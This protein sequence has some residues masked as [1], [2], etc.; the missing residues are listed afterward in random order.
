MAP[1]YILCICI[2]HTAINNS[3][4]EK[5]MPFQFFIRLT[6]HHVCMRRFTCLTKEK[7]F[8]AT[9]IINS[10]ALATQNFNANSKKRG[11]LLSSI[12]IPWQSYWYWY[13]L[14]DCVHLLLVFTK[15][16]YLHAYRRMAYTFITYQ[17]V[18]LRMR[19]SIDF[20]WNP[21]GKGKF[22]SVS[23]SVSE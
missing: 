5:S 10:L 11:I 12:H 2:Q 21:F 3:F 22:A 15:Y 17:S 19:E 4:T 14:M 20:S 23:F 6:K 18:L 16:S 13:G 7:P 1:I 9:I 8:K